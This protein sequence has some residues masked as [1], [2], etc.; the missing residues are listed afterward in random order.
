MKSVWQTNTRLHVETINNPLFDFTTHM[1]STQIFAQ[2]FYL[3]TQG[4]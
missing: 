2:N 4:E 3:D 1:N